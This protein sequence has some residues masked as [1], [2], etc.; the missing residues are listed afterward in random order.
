MKQNFGAKIRENILAKYLIP[1]E[2]NQ[3]IIIIFFFCFWWG[4]GVGE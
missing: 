4:L 1:R 2:L 3:F